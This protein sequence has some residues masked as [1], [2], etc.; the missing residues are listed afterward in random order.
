MAPGG[1]MGQGIRTRRR[2]L[3]LAVAG[4][5]LAA[6]GMPTPAGESA[7]QSVAPVTL[8]FFARTSEDE[9]FTKRTAQFMEQHPTIKLEFS[10]LPGDYLEV[11]RTHAVAGTLSDAV[12]MQNLLFE[13]LAAGGSIQPIDRLVQR[14]KVDLK[15]WFEGGINALK[16]DG[17]L[18]GLPARGQIGYCFLFYNT[19][20]LQQ[21]GVREPTETWTLD[22]LGAAAE[23]ATIR[24]GSRYGYNTQWGNF[25]HTLAA[26]RRWGGDLLSADGKKCTAET[27][28]A[29]QAVQWHWEL[30]HRR[31]VMH[32]K[33]YTDAQFGNGEI[34][35][36]G[37][38]LAGARSGLKTAA[39][40]AF[41]WDMVMMPKGP[42]GKIGA[43]LSVA[44]VGLSAQTK[45]TD[46][47]WEVVR[48]FSDKETGVQ[49]GLQTRGSNTPGMRR[50]VYCDERLLSD[51]SYPRAMLDRVCKAMDNA[52]TITYSVAANLRQNDVNAVISKHMNAVRENTVSPNAATMRA[53][54]QEMQAVLDQPRG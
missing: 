35:M 38:M 15:Q 20:A 27:P 9:A 22:D 8:S 3:A 6:C 28:Q 52:S 51:A 24:D 47:A 36:A 12:Y 39:K 14:D 7:A 2:A 13:G 21:V 17:K 26:I 18:F 40:D 53:V 34:V 11:I 10:A 16:L 19:D 5:A 25:Q 44:P 1:A 29:L 48:W 43:E 32:P 41:K 33:P 23:K 4:G 42:S 50:D 37:Q 49:L 30:W 45:A 46:A 54:T 31:Q